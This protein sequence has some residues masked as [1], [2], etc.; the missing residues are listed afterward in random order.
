MPRCPL[1]ISASI[2]S[3]LGDHPSGQN[4]VSQELG[5]G[6][7]RLREDIQDP[8]RMEELELSVCVCDM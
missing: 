3:G 8:D 6:R 7:R 4:Y 2:D 1:H 5:L